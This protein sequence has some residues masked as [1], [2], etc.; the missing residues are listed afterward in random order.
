VIASRARYYVGAGIAGAIVGD[1]FAAGLAA[2]LSQLAPATAELHGAAALLYSGALIV[3]GLAL[4]A[5]CAVALLRRWFWSIDVAAAEALPRL[6]ARA[7]SRMPR[8]IRRGRC[9][10]IPDASGRVERC[11][12][13]GA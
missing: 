2:V 10:P 13:R 5:W 11:S 3:L 8:P 4:G 6:H 12:A 1:L 9:T 7:R